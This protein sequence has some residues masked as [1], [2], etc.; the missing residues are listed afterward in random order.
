M[1]V[2]LG[3]GLRSSIGAVQGAANE[4]GRITV[5]MINTTN[6]YQGPA[7]NAGLQLSTRL[8][9]GIRSGIGLVQTNSR[10]VG[11]M[12]KELVNAAVA[13]QTPAYNAGKGVA[14]K[15]AS[16]LKDGQSGVKTAASNTGGAA[17]A[18]ADAAN[19]QRGDAYSAGQNIARGLANGIS[20]G[21]GWIISAARSAVR[22]GINAGKDE[23]GIASPSKVA[24]FEIGQMWGK[25]LALGIL[26]SSREIEE[27]VKDTMSPMTET[28]NSD[29]G[30]VNA[31][32]QLSGGNLYNAVK[33]GMESANLGIYLDGREVGRTVR[34]M[35]GGSVAWA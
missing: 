30:L 14:D 20:D 13:Q 5:T 12:T 24:R 4:V 18:L 32:N 1:G 35:R 23:A 3:S 7:N 8:A 11:E 9:T 15:L 21:V 10:S 27:A 34:D 25:G 16:G 19:D 29:G 33:E 17:S 26:D 28:F 22:Q 31:L 6:S 2:S